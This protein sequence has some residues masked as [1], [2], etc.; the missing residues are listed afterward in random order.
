MKNSIHSWIHTS[1]DTWNLEEEVLE[2]KTFGQCWGQL[3]GLNPTQENTQDWLE[4]DEEH[5]EFQLLTE[6]EIAAMIFLFIFIST[7]SL[8][9]AFICFIFIVLQGYLLSLFWIIA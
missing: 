2:K 5:P 3:G 6:E 7:T 1:K 9:F 4:L 8:H